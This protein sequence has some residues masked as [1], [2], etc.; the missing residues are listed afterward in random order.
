MLDRRGTDPGIGM[1]EPQVF[2]TRDSGTGIHLQGTPRARLKHLVGL[3]RSQRT[4]R[5]AATAVHHN[6][7]GSGRAQ[8]RQIRQQQG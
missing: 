1:H 3:R 6:Q 7:F 2:S 4:G 8:R 5:V